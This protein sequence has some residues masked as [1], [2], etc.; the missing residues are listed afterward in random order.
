MATSETL[1]LKLTDVPANLPRAKSQIDFSTSSSNRDP[2]SVQLINFQWV[3]ATCEL[4]SH[5]S[6]TR[7][8]RSLVQTRGYGAHRGSLR[9]SSAIRRCCSFY[10]FLSYNF[11]CLYSAQLRA[12]RCREAIAAVLK[13]SVEFFL[14]LRCSRFSVFFLG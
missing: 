4:G 1:L 5:A 9:F 11:R 14:V 7:G 3:G 13:I 12:D 6:L 2:F 10:K 8:Y